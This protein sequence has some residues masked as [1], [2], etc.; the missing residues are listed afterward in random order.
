[1]ARRV[2]LR[3]KLGTARSQGWRSTCLAFA[4]SAAHEV[5]LFDDIDITDTCEEYLHWASKQHDDPGPGTT[6]P[7]A[8]DALANHGQ[9]LEEVWPYEPDRDDENPGYQPPALAHTAAPRWTPDFA[10]VPATPNSLKVEI[11]AGRA[12]VLGIP[13]WPDFDSPTAGRLL[14]P[15]LTDLDGAYHA[16]TIIGYDETTAEMLIRNSWGPDWGDDGTAWI[17]LRFLDEHICEA[18]VLNANPAAP[19]GPLTAPVRYGRSE[20]GSPW[21]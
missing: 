1:V 16:V 9:P 14:V 3:S 15:D 7:A 4:I 10:A 2:D 13:T 11:D 12:V 19:R 17:A 18:W 6:F 21:N 8:R 20:L 5:D